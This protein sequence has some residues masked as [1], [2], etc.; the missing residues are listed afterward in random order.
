MNVGIGVW[1]MIDTSPSSIRLF[2][3]IV[4]AVIWFWVLNH[5]VE[6]DD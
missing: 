4:L 5:P 2:A 6:D 3:I 1:E